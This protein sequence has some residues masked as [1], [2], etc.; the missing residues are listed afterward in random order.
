[1]KK[2]NGNTHVA[3]PVKQLSVDNVVDAGHF[4]SCQKNR[5][6]NPFVRG[7]RA[8]CSRVLWIIEIETQ[9]AEVTR[10]PV[11]LMLLEKPQLAGAGWRRGGPKMKKNEVPAKGVKLLG[12]PRK[13]RQ[14]KVGSKQRLDE[15]RLDRE[16]QALHFL[17]RAAL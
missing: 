13:V 6:R 15:P 3:M 11:G 9:N 1:D 4:L 8:D 5:Q 10:S 14:G 17:R 12:V 2:R 7:K 16:R